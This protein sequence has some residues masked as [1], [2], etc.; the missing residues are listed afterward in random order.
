MPPLLAP[1]HLPCPRPVKPVQR[2]CNPLSAT[3]INRLATSQHVSLSRTVYAP[4]ASCAL[5]SY[6]QTQRGTSA[7]QL[8]PI[9]DI[10]S[11]PTNSPFSS[12]HDQLKHLSHTHVSDSPCGPLF[13]QLSIYFYNALKANKSHTNNDLLSHPLA[14]QLQAGNHRASFSPYFKLQQHVQELD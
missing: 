1:S 7:Q 8:I 5:I 6:P 14:S 11:M 9:V 3:A 12:Q 10:P 4:R 13:P 2:N